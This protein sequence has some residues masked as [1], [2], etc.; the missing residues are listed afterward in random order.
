MC[1]VVALAAS[2]APRP[3]ELLG[4]VRAQIVAASAEGL[5]A[6]GRRH[7]VPDR[8]ATAH[9]PGAV[10][11]ARPSIGVEVAGSAELA[12]LGPARVALPPP[13]LA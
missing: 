7:A 11:A 2:G 6:H 8:G 3:A 5:P 13:A 4:L 10:P 12:R 1:L 9:R